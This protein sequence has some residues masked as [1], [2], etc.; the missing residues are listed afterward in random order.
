MDPL[1]FCIAIAPLSVYLLLIAI[2]NLGRTPF[3]TTGARDVAALGIG[4]LGFVVAGPMELFFPES[5]AS[6]YGSLVWVMMIIFY[7]LIVSLIVLMMRARIVV[8]NVTV[9]Q[10][11]PILTSVAMRLDPR[12]R[13]AGNSLMIPNRQIHLH[14]EPTPWLRNSQL[15]SGG[16]EQSHE[17]WRELEIE[18][19]SALKEAKVGPNLIALPLLFISAALAV[20]A[21]IWMLQDKTAVAEAFEEMRRM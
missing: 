3:V 1:H 7:G 8:Y 2:L 9:E 10:L 17:G 4:V 21:A 19:S 15:T 12:S 5:A 16:I 11:R 13:W 6:Q 18:L 20:G 14:L